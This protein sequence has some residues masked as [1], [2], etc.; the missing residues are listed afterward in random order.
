MRIKRYLM[1]LASPDSGRQEFSSPKGIGKITE[2]G[3]R[4]AIRTVIRYRNGLVRCT[5]L[6]RLHYYWRAA[7]AITSSESPLGSVVEHSLHTRGVRSSNLL[8]G[9]NIFNNLRATQLILASPVFVRTH[10][11]THFDL[12]N[13][14]VHELDFTDRGLSFEHPPQILKYLRAVP[15]RRKVR[16]PAPEQSGTEP[17]EPTTHL[18]PTTVNRI[19]AAVSTFYE[20]LIVADSSPSVTEHFV[21]LVVSA[22][23]SKIQKQL[24]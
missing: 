13:D 16:K 21:K 19:L 17:E 8:A 6:T 10:V 12:K 4:A 23:G 2:A 14:H 24:Q 15:S 1:T 3:T 7:P 11:R 18:A 22:K 9:T 5:D 20:Y